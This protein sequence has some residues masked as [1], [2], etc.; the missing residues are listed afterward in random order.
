[1]TAPRTVLLLHGI[2]SSHTTWW[3]VAPE[4]EARGWTVTAL[5]LAGHGGRPIGDI[6][7]ARG[8]AEDV[9]ARMPEGVTL[10]VGHSLGAIVALELA[11]AHPD[12]ALGVLIED[13]PAIGDLISANDVA[14]DI[15]A[16]LARAQADR[17]A[18]V[19]A[20]LSEHP[21]YERQ[22]AEN[23]IDNLL[24]TDVLP[25]LATLEN[26][27]WDLPALVAA[28]PVPLA[29]VA[30]V[31]PESMLV[32]PDRDALLREI[33]PERVSEIPSGHSVHRDAGPAWLDAVT[34]FGDTL[35]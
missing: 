8:L 17:D 20:V 10:L 21:S 12:F 16:E 31:G 14:T 26:S 19:Q 29:L 5:D 4:L 25:M 7:T 1:V 15:L 9:V 35:L 32:D 28:C 33:Q 13:P 30:A 11:A 34:A 22:D 27:T 23:S 3:H 24:S 18:A 6:T 2:T